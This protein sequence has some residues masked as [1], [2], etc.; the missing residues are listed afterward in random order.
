MIK[1]LV[2]DSTF[3]LGIDT[4]PDES[5]FR[6]KEDELISNMGTQEEEKVKLVGGSEGVSY[7]YG[8][9]I[10]WKYKILRLILQAYNEPMLNLHFLNPFLKNNM[11]SHGVYDM[12]F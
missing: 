9:D 4:L 3:V 2:E 11:P 6:A 10:V 12:I 1:E 8:K 5:G 7:S